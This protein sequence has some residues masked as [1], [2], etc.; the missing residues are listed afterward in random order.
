MSDNK[1]EL[2]SK[3]INALEP[4]TDPDYNDPQ[5]GDNIVGNVIEVAEKLGIVDRFYNSLRRAPLRKLLAL[6]MFIV[7][8]IIIM[9]GLILQ[10]D[11]PMEISSGL[12]MV[13]MIIYGGYFGTSA[14]EAISD[15]I[16]KTKEVVSNGINV[17]NI[18]SFLPDLIE[19]R[20]QLKE[21]S[22]EEIEEQ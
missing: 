18:I 2:L 20:D 4:P 19:L 13:R 7:D 16:Q 3:I 5:G 22:E 17:K 21:R 12:S 6:I 14:A 11:L 8:I 9:V 10:R 1:L 15:K